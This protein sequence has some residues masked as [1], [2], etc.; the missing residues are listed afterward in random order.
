M[1]ATR[2][3]RRPTS[4]R[5]FGVG[6]LA[7]GIATMHGRRAPAAE[8][9]PIDS[10]TH[11]FVRGLPLAADARTRPTNDVSYQR[12]LAMAE[13]NGIGRVVI[14]Q[15]SFLGHDNS[16][17]LRALAAQPGHL[18]GVPWIAPRTTTRQWDEMGR[19]RRGRSALPDSWPAR[20]GL[21]RLP[22]GVRGGAAAQ[23]APPPLHRE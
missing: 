22:G 20:A 15:P 1:S 8:L 23:L 10:H 14:A 21:G 13:S 12:L 6:A 16:Y 9:L 17:L 18:R 7:L 19:A 2:A 3:A 5:E 11:T 4:R